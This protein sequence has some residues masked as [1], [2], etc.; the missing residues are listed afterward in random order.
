MART[1]RRRA[2]KP[3]GY[4]F[5]QKEP[6]RRKDGKPACR[7][8]LGA[9]EKPRRSFCSDACVQEWKRRTDF[10]ITRRMVFDRDG[11]Q[12]QLCRRDCQALDLEWLQGQTYHARWWLTASPEARQK[13]TAKGEIILDPEG[14]PLPFAYWGRLTDLAIQYRVDNKLPLTHPGWEVDHIQPVCEGGDY[15]DLQNLRLLCQPCHALETAKLAKRR[16][17]AKRKDRTR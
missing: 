8:C 7:W 14:S 12:C 2:P 3:K 1:K 4:H 17:A 10:A 5:T 11:G 13:L 6:V 16:A 9:V 15:F